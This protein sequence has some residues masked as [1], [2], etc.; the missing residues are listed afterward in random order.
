M[1]V[2]AVG[3]PP[4]V[5]DGLTH[6]VG[7]TKPLEPDDAVLSASVCPGGIVNAGYARTAMNVLVFKTNILGADCQ[8]TADT[9]LQSFGT[10]IYWT[11]DLDDCDKI[12]R[13]VT[14]TVT[15]PAIVQAMRRAGFICEELP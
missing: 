8:Q 9:A 2:F 1:A 11:V 10:A 5:S 12:L 6:F 7:D 15:A 4:V 13:V 14:D 3:R